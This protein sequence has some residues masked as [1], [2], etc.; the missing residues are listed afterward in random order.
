MHHTSMSLLQR[1]GS[2]RSVVLLLVP[3]GTSCPHGT[4]PEV[5]PT[6]G[7]DRTPAVLKA[8]VY[9]PLFGADSGLRGPVDLGAHR[10][11]VGPL[12]TP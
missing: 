12:A 5:H 2:E 8:F 7:V 3:A 11:A 6:G 4:I 10:H 9:S 1:A